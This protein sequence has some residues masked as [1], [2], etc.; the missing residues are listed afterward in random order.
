MA[1]VA[2][3]AVGSA[4]VGGTEMEADGRVMGAGAVVALVGLCLL[5]MLF[6]APDTEPAERGATTGAAE[7]SSESTRTPVTRRAPAPGPAERAAASA[8][9]RPA[10]AE[11]DDEPEEVAS[12]VE[13]LPPLPPRTVWPLTKEGIDGGMKEILGDIL[14]CYQAALDEFPELAGGFS[15]FFTVEEVEGVGEVVELEI[16]DPRSERVEALVDGPMEECVMDHVGSLQFDAPADGRTSVDYP[17]MF[18]PG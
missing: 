12:T 9:A 5:W 6:S 15:V 7:P 4:R 2:E 16:R 14:G 1:S 11:A 3:A 13:E 18:A 8:A 17:F 10:A